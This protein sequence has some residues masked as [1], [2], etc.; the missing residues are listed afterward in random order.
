[1]IHRS[2]VSGNRAA[3]AKDRNIE[4][5][6][7]ATLLSGVLNGFHGTDLRRWCYPSQD[8]LVKGAIAGQGGNAAARQIG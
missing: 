5:R 7:R 4:D 1:M 2:K 6:R 3:F 8:L